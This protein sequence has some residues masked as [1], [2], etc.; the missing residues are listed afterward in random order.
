MGESVAGPLRVSPPR[1]RAHLILWPRG[2]TVLAPVP[3]IRSGRASGAISSSE[4]PAGC[5]KRD[6]GA[7]SADGADE[8]PTIREDDDAGQGGAGAGIARIVCHDVDGDVALP[9]H[10]V[11]HDRPPVV[12]LDADPV[13]REYAAVDVQYPGRSDADSRVI[14]AKALR[15]TKAVASPAAS[16]LGDCTGRIVVGRVSFR[17]LA[18]ALAIAGLQ[19]QGVS[20]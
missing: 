6:V 14:P 1:S 13:E 19:T 20:T 12:A 3:Q 7:R 11:G 8:V 18:Y 16:I 9:E 5:C 2:P 17:L 15:V 4:C 10:R